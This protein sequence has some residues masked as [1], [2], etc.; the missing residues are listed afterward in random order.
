MPREQ[1]LVTKIQNA[2]KSEYPGECWLYKTDGNAAKNG[3]PDI[4]G[5]VC[6][7]FI[8]LEVKTLKGRVRKN[9]EVQ[10]AR[11]RKAGGRACVVRCVGD[12]LWSVGM[13]TG[14]RE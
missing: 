3:A 14:F 2:L 4:I 12:A 13:W 9:Q 6:G 1:S 11:I 10:M 7:V 5:V 8:G